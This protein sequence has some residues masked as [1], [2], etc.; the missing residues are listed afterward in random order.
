MLT[1]KTKTFF[2]MLMG[3]LCYALGAWADDSVRRTVYGWLRYEERDAYEQGLVRFYTDNASTLTPAYTDGCNQAA[4]AGAYADGYYY[5]YLYDTD[6]YNA[7]PIA[8]ERMDLET[9][10]RTRVADYR[11]W[12]TLYQDMAFDPT[13]HTL[14]ALGYDEGTYTSRLLRVDL[15]DGQAYVVGEMDA[16]KYVALA[17]NAEG[18]LYALDVDY[19]Q[20]WKVDKHTAEA[21]AIGDTGER[22]YD[23]LQSMT[24]DLETGVLYWA[25]YEAWFRLDTVTGQ[26]T[27][28]GPLGMYAQVVGLHIPYKETEPGAPAEITDLSVSPG[29]KGALTARL[30]WTNP[31]TTFGGE[32]LGALTEV[33]VTRGDEVVHTLTNPQ[34]GARCEWTDTQVPHAGQATYRVSAANECG[35]STSEGRTAF[36]GRDRPAAPRDVTL[37]SPDRRQACLAWKAPG[38]GM[39][40]GWVDTSMLTY[41][42]VRWPD[43]IRVAEGVTANSWTDESVDSLGRYTYAIQSCNVDGAGGTALSPTCLLGP[44]IQT[45]YTCRFATQEEFDLWSVRDANADGCTWRRETTLAAAYYAYNPDGTTP[46]DDWLTSPPIWMERGKNYR[47]RYQLQSY[48]PSM[49]ERVAVWIGTQADEQETRIADHVVSANLFETYTAELPAE[50][51]TGEYHLSFHCH[52]AADKFILYVGGIVVEEVR[53]GSIEGTVRDGETPLEGVDVCATETGRTTRTDSSGRY[54]L[55]EL[56]DGTYSLRFEKAGYAT[57]TLTGIEVRRGETTQADASMQALPRCSLSGRTVN[58]AGQPVG[59]A[60]LRL[61]GAESFATESAADGTFAFADVPQATYVLS[62]ERYGLQTD[63]RT[64]DL[65]AGGGDMGDLVLADKR[66]APWR[67]TA[68]LHDGQMSIAWEQPRDIRTYRHDNGVHGGRLGTPGSTARS[69]YGAVFRTPALLTGMSWLTESYLTTHPVVNVF[70]FDLDEEGEPTSHLLYSRQDAPNQDDEWTELAFPTPVDAPRGYMLAISCEGHVGLGLDT[71]EGPDHPFAEHV[72]CYAE[73]YTTGQFTYTEEHDI[74]RTLMIRGEGTN[75]G[76]T[77]LPDATTGRRYAVW[78]VP[79]GQT[80]DEGAWT[81]LTPTPQE[82]CT[83][84]D[85]AWAT[86]PQGTYRYAVKTYYGTDGQPSPAAFTNE[87]EKDLYT[88]ISLHV[89]TRTPQNEAEGACVVLTHAEQPDRYA[90]QA[91]AEADGRTFFPRVRKGV[92]R[93]D[94]TR[95]GFYD[96]HV[97]EADFTTEATYDRTGDVLEE[98]VVAPFNL[99]VR[100]ASDEEGAW[101]LRWNVTDHLADDFEQHADFA[102]HSAGTVG[103]TYADLDGK[104]T[105]GIDGVNYPNATTPKAFFV[106]NPSA[107]DPAI[108][109][110]DPGTRA[111][112][113]QRYLAA[114]P[115]QGSANNDFLFSPALDFARPFTLRFYAKSYTDLYGLEELNVGYSRAECRAEDFEWVNGDTPIGVPHTAW[116]VYTYTLPPTARYIA[117]NCVSDQRF[118]LMVDD[119]FIGIEKPE[120]I[121]PERIKDGV[122]YEIWADGQYVGSTTE[123]AY[124]LPPLAPGR[125]RAEVRARFAS[126]VTEPAELTFD[127]TPADGLTAKPE[128]RPNVL[129]DPATRC[130]RWEGTTCREAWLTDPAGRLCAHAVGTQALCA[131][132]LLPGIYLLRLR[133]D[134]GFYT[135]KVCLHP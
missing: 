39:N 124:R 121:E 16:G 132:G 1:M 120:G 96:L 46:A 133:T 31:T 122:T 55:P 32:A 65:A 19:G 28:I 99:E 54:V 72:N 126:A 109:L 5:V 71:G 78:L 56:P 112:S 90:Y 47:V 107:T 2:L 51:E 18:Q 103:W 84:T 77:D 127:T 37:T 41:T 64:I 105:Y 118:F 93:I 119:I 12:S 26:A 10:V 95:K 106:F 123:C 74:R 24:F 9:G 17:C 91:T 114:F 61:E 53:D 85:D 25:G 117:L 92:Y 14:F 60:R 129:F 40:G 69:V 115:S 43:S 87:C 111:H 73:D 20:L 33:R 59:Y 4:C 49:P 88:A 130:F 79:D 83:W 11:G 128:V 44:S 80:D 3:A 63:Q 6:G 30:T 15:T 70:V 27:R 67:P 29:E 21:T 75:R 113:G 135:C 57:Q 34:P 81:L 108:S 110:S 68:T 42:V 22:I 45:P 48:G 76:D 86:R 94:I 89:Q 8:L 102:V 131:E 36:V 38:E 98:Y 58:A 100:A 97:E 62:T 50:R 35:S 104:P 23:D 134:V 101:T 125:H 13:T 66:L 7:T 116:T 82:S 52:S